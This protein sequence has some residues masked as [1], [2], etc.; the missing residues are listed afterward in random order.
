MA[1]IIRI[2][3]LCEEEKV[4]CKSHL[5]PEYLYKSC[6]DNNRKIVQLNIKKKRRL[7]VQKGIWEYLLCRECEL[8]LSKIENRF[9]RSWLDEQRLPDKM[10]REFLELKGLD[11][12]QF[13]LFHLS[14]LWRC[15]VSKSDFT[16][17]VN[18]D[19]HENSIASLILNET[20]DK[21]SRYRIWGSVLIWE[22]EDNRVVH[23]C[24]FFPQTGKIEG[25]R[26]Y[27]IGYAG[28]EWG[29][30]IS[31]HSTHQFR[32]V[33]LKDDGSIILP[34]MSL[35]RIWKKYKIRQELQTEGGKDFT[36]RYINYRS[37]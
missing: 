19:P 29:F 32:N 9:K 24:V 22:G 34:C 37:G 7:L 14:V 4:L 35:E 15:S 23:E 25:H 2:C 18:L 8:H 1:K 10:N 16:A 26:V 6:Y 13:K 36:R 31:N 5:I 12:P 33:C 17:N 28:C 30:F 3:K 11:Y 21:E 20:P 27:K